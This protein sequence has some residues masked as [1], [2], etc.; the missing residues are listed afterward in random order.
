MLTMMAKLT[1]TWLEFA[2]LHGD[3]TQTMEEV[4]VDTFF[5]LWEFPF[6]GGQKL[7]PILHYRQAKQNMLV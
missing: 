5:T 1:G 4:L 3:Q 2:I 7:N 6:H